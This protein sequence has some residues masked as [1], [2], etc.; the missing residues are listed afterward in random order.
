M[1]HSFTV[2]EY[3]VLCYVF[4]GLVFADSQIKDE[5]IEFLAF[6]LILSNSMA[7]AVVA[8]SLTSKG[9]RRIM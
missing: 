7:S 2:H 5:L 8:V 9:Y 1:L 4:V 6:I 3:N